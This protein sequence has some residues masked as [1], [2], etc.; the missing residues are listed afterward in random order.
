[1]EKTKTITEV[2]FSFLTLETAAEK[3]ISRQGPLSSRSGAFKHTT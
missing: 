3:T 2:Q 1:M